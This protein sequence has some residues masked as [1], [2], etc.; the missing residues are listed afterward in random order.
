MRLVIAL[1]VLIS[2]LAPAMAQDIQQCGPGERWSSTTQKCE[3]IGTTEV[4]CTN[5]AACPSGYICDLSHTNYG[6]CIQQSA[7]PYCGDD[8]CQR[9]ESVLS[10][11]QDCDAN[12]VPTT[13]S[14]ESRSLT[15]P[16]IIAAGLIAAAIILRHGKKSKKK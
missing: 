8:I 5:N 10:C 15:G 13:Q 1:L 3:T 16:I 12:Y 14:S 4:E 9:D 11:P 7:A 6:N 2:I